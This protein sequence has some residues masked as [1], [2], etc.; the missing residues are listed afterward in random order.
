MRCVDNSPE[1]FVGE[2]MA[3]TT[4][5]VPLQFSGL[6]FG[7]NTYR[8]NEFPG[9]EL[10]SVRRSTAV[11]PVQPFLNVVCH[12]DVGLLRVGNTA[13]RYT[14]QIH[15]TAL[16]RPAAVPALRYEGHPSLGVHNHASA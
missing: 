14:Y 8:G 11:V 4:F 6:V 3:G 2:G 16:L 9:T 5:E 12:P 13:L 10:R 1:V 15:A 7:R